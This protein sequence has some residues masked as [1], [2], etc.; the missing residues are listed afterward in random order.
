MTPR[1]DVAEVKNEL[2]RCRTP[3]VMLRNTLCQRNQCQAYC[4]V[5]QRPYNIR[6]LLHLR[7]SFCKVVPREDILFHVEILRESFLALFQLEVH[8]GEPFPS[9]FLP[10]KNKQC[11]CF[12]LPPDDCHDRGSPCWQ[13]ISDREGSTK[14]KELPKVL[15]SRSWYATCIAVVLTQL[16]ETWLWVRCRAIGVRSLR[17]N[18]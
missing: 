5:R 4:T 9:F 14:T 17:P 2:E 10:G 3:H 12:I 18:G 7:R 15:E 13:R 16:I 1:L 8:V 6:L 11:M